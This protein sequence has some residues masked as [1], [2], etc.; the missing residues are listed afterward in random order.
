MKVDRNINY[1]YESKAFGTARVRISPI[2]I[3]ALKLKHALQ[4][5]EAVNGKV[6]DIGCGGG[7]M[8]EALSYYRPDL[9]VW[10]CDISANSLSIARKVAREVKFCFGDIF[11]LPFENNSFDAIVMFDFLEHFEEPARVLQEVHRVLVHEGIFHTAVPF[12]GDVRTL[13]GILCRMGWKAKEI[14]C[15]HVQMYEIGQPESLIRDAGFRIVDRRWT[16]HF[17]Y[18]LA[19]VL[20]FTWLYARGNGVPYSI[21][22]YLEVAKPSLTRRAVFGVKALVASLSYLESSIFHWLPAGFGHFTCINGNY[23]E[24]A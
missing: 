10:G 19:D 17:V 23:D 21:E 8:T 24:S 16:A 5:L 9:E 13:H 7:G 3:P 15:G 22:G 4:G 6:L 11:Q 18:Q 2:Y 12:E 1:D 20:Y 14:H